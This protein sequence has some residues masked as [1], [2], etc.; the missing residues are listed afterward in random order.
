MTVS[1]RILL[2]VALGAVFVV[3]VVTAVTHQ[4]VFD[5]LRHRDL[6]HLDT[7]V[8]ERAEREEARFQVVQTNLRLVRGQFLKRL[9]TPLSP[10]HVEERFNYWNRRYEDGAWRTREPFGDARKNASFW[11]DKEWPATP[12]MRRQVVIVQELCDEMLPGW[13]DEFPSYYF[14]FPAPGLVNAGVD[15][16]L[17]DWSW[18]MPAHFDTTGLEWVALALP[19]EVPDPDRFAWTGL[20]QDDVISEPLVGVFLPVIKDGVFVASVGHNMALSRLIDAAAKSAIPGASHYIFRADGRLIAHPPRRAE[21]LASKG[22]LTAQDCGDP[23]LASLYRIATAHPE[24]RFTGFD[25]VSGAH[26]SVA[27]LAGPEWFYVTTMSEA[28]LR[29]QA[30]ASAQ[31]VLWSGLVS[32]ALVL[33]FLAVTLHRQVARPLAELTR[34]TDAMSAG[35]A[36]VPIPHVRADELGTL[37][38]SFSLMVD[39]V[40]AREADLRQLNL[41][42]EKRVAD[43]TEDLRSALTRERELGEMKTHFT[44]LVSHEFRTPLGI[45][46]SSAQILDRY[47][48]RLDDDERRE[49]LTNINSSVKRMAAMMEEMLMLSRMDSGRMDFKPAPITLGD[50]CRRLVDELRSAHGSSAG[51]HIAP[52]AEAPACADEALVRHILTNLLTNAHKYSPPGAPVQ[53]SLTRDDD[54]AIFTVRDEGIGIPEADQPRLFEAFYR[55]TNVGEVGGTGLGLVVVRRCCELHG[56][57]VSVASREGAGTTFTVRIPAFENLHCPTP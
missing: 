9:E 16:L 8:R 31:W 13:V 46:G 37:A 25:P 14:Q 3:A 44:S 57:S 55:G 28:H 4:L 40:A 29:A 47:L 1:R 45:I 36:E 35:S 49:H 7:Y 43:Q 24:R 17:A 38:Q 56:G 32:L 51:L 30:F 54:T 6:Q 11:A 21:I 23:T 22:L 48:A 53:L 34:A 39:R 19:A 50:L 26:Y 12:E 10:E 2:H 20:Q 27:R 42:L 18:K 15:V 52:D 33:G 5:A 41:D